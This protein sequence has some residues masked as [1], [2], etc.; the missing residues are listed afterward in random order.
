MTIK[1][2]LRLLL[3]LL[4]FWG[5]SAI[6]GEKIALTPQEKTYLQE[7]PVLTLCVDPDW[8]PY[9]KINE[10][11]QHVGLVAEYLSVMQNRLNI[12]FNV[13]KTKSWEETQ[14]AYQNGSCDVVSAL[15][16]T[17][18]RQQ[19]LT[20]TKPYITSPAVLAVNSN[21]KTA[22]RLADLKGKSLGMVKGYV[23]DSKLRQQYPDIKIKYFM[24]MEDALKSVSAGEIDATLGPL[25]LLFALTQEM[26]L[27][28][29]KIIGD[30][31]YQDELRIGIK[32]SDTVLAGIFS[33]A[34]S[35]ITHEDNAEI[36]K[37]WAQKRQSY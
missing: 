36:R 16:K 33:K 12:S 14:R 29:V 2:R 3:C 8:L 34:V 26:N 18:Q 9:E 4:G 20:F 5:A 7:H 23:Y 15:N 22:T 35:S 6:A 21:N 10:A 32:I 37:S 17:P 31:E 1:L 19:F 28:S 30:S 11:G 25:F 13:L 27:N 24:N